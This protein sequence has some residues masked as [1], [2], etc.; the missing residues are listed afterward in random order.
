MIIQQTEISSPRPVG[1]P[2]RIRIPDEEDVS[3]PKMDPAS[4][5]AALMRQ[6][7]ALI[8]VKRVSL[9]TTLS[10]REIQRRVSEK[11]FPSPIQIGETRK[12]WKLSVI[13][14]WLQNPTF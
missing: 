10:I 8:D 7:D 5:E 3:I 12:A 2:P 11:R 6:V 9:L 1:R 4:I 13:Q 14:N